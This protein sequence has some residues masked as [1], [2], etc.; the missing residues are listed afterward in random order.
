MTPWVPSPGII[1]QWCGIVEASNM[2][3]EQ[4]QEAAQL[5]QDRL[6]RVEDRS[7]VPPFFRSDRSPEE[8]QRERAADLWNRR[9]DP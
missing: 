5:A 4:L 9:E 7:L 6:D 8:L 1:G 2:T 3:Q